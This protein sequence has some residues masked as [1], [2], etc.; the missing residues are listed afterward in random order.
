M[1]ERN[2]GEKCQGRKE[3][4]KR[5]VDNVKGRKNVLGKNATDIEGK[6]RIHESQREV[7]GHASSPGKRRRK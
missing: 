7:K 4:L 6:R 1:A 5:D 2:K 3:W